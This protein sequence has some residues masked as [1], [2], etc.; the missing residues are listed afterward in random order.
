MGNEHLFMQH[1][2]ILPLLNFN[3]TTEN[4]TTHLTG[5]G[6]ENHIKVFANCVKSQTEVESGHKNN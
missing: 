2:E 5:W 4:N 6:E 1:V 3:D